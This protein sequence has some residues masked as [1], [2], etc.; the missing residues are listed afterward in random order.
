MILFFIWR[1]LEH[2]GGYTGQVSLGH[3]AFFGLGAGNR[4][5]WFA[6]WNVIL[7]MLVGG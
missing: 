6:G 3:S 1:H 4:L 2:L 5:L 7:G